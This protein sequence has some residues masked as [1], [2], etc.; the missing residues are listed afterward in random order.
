MDFKDLSYLVA[1]AKYGNITKASE[2]VYI[3]QPTLTKF[4]QKK[5]RELGLKLFKKVGN[6]FILTYSGQKYVEKATMI[7][8]LKK[9]LD[10]EMNDIIKKNEG[11]LKGAFPAM[12]STYMLPCTLPI[13][14]SLYP[15]VHLNILE[16]NSNKLE[17]MILDGTTDLAFFN[18]PIHSSNIDYELISHEELLL[19]MSPDNPLAQSAVKNSK[20]K[21]PYMDIDLIKDEKFIL[22]LPDQRTR[23]TVNHLIKTTGLQPDIVL[24]TGNFSASVELVSK[25]YGI[26]FMTETHLKHIKTSRPVLCFSIGKPSTTVDFVAAFHKGSY[27]SYHAKEY[28]KIVR[29][30]T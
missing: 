3:S 26:C 19:V 28:I 22:P 20:C 16:A 30:F 6:K 7:L 2:S 17:E 18:L 9:Q 10:Q 29:D 24:E 5:E 1:I 12:R 21:F 11:S 23:Q 13:F 25:N 4:L 14:H 15:N 27:I 8:D